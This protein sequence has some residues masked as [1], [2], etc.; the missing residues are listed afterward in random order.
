MKIKMPDLDVAGTFIFTIGAMMYS[1]A[2][3]VTR[4]PQECQSLF[5]FS[6]AVLLIFGGYKILNK[7]RKEIK[8]EEM[9]K[10]E[11]KDLGGHNEKQQH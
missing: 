7:Y 5:N 4:Y 10:L 9:E 1:L 3:M 8:K 11:S 6:A 2:R